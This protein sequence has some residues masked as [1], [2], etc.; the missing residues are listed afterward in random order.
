MNGDILIQFILLAAV[1]VLFATD[2]IR[3]DAVAIGLIL[4]L[5]LTKQLTP[6]QAWRASATL[7]S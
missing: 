6:V 1:I 3:P 2:R 4:A 5:I 7:W